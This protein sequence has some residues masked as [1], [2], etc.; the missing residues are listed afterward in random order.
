MVVPVRV[1]LARTKGSQGTQLAHT[2][3]ATANG[4]RLAGFRGDVKVGDTIEIQPRHDWARFRVIWIHASE[5]SSEK[6][7]GAECIEP[8]KNIWAVEFPQ[9]TDDTVVTAFELY[10]FAD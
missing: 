1:R 8:D 5:K 3:D 9:Q 4:V 10:T 6:H 2:L 7:I